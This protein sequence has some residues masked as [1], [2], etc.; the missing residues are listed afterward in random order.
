MNDTTRLSDALDRARRNEG[1]SI[2]LHAPDDPA[3]AVIVVDGPQARA[4]IALQGA[5]VLSWRPRGGDDA[6]WCSPMMAPG[7]AA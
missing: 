2:E 3:S 6:L 5:Q 7:L 4:R 1:V